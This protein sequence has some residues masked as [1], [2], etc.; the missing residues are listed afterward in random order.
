MIEVHPP[1]L[2]F[3]RLSSREEYNWFCS[4]HS[5]NSAD[6]GQPRSRL[7]LRVGYCTVTVADKH[8]ARICGLVRAAAA[9]NIIVKKIQNKPLPNSR[10]RAVAMS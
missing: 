10:C 2:V 6:R 4:V 7:S 3:L 8:T 9:I 1:Q 5:R